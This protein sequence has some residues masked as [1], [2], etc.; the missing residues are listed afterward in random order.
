MLKNIF[1][2][3]VRGFTI[4]LV[5]LGIV[6]IYVFDPFIEGVQHYPSHLGLERG[7]Y[8][9]DPEAILTSLDRVETQV[10][11]PEISS[12]ENPIFEKY[13]SWR[14]SD[15][16]KITAALHQFVWGEGLN[17][18]KLYNMY[19]GT[20]CHDNLGGFELGK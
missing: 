13:F 20:P 17:D 14:Q 15:Y 16:T 4:C 19:F 5:I 2:W 18:W 7:Y 12:P 10:F 1:K 6:I 8:T 11:T 3:V 9:I